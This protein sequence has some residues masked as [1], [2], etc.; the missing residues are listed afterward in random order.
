MSST[1]N[2]NRMVFLAI[3]NGVKGPPL[4]AC[5][6]TL[7][8]LITWV[9]S[10]VARAGADQPSGKE[11]E[12]LWEWARKATP[13]AVNCFYDVNWI[14]CVDPCAP[15]GADLIELADHDDW[16]ASVKELDAARKEVTT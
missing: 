6:G 11:Y 12:A 7:M 13:G 8:G 4:T 15:D 10:R 5:C 2:V 3:D 1:I 16:V 9:A 14:V